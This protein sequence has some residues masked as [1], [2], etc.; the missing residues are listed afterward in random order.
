M[1]KRAK[2]TNLPDVS[3]QNYEIIKAGIKV[4]PDWVQDK[5]TKKWNWYIFYND[6]G[7]IVRYNKPVNSNDLNLS[8]HLSILD[9]YNKLIK[10]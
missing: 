5:I 3:K 9:R 7:N 4:F 1:S 10:K 6:N 8:I 2:I